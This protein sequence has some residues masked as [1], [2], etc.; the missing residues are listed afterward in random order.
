MLNLKPPFFRYLSYLIGALL[1]SFVIAKSNLSCFTHDESYTYLSFPHYS[2]MDIVSYKQSYTNNHLLNTLLMK[3]SERVFGNSELALRLPNILLFVVYMVF[4][5]LF[6]RKRK[7]LFAFSMFVLLCTNP[8]LVDLFGLARG[9]GL[10][11]GFMLMSLYFFI[12]Y[13]RQGG[14]KNILFFHFGAL[15]A[16]LSSFT[17][18]T[19]YAA[20]LLVFN[21]LIFL[22][23]KFISDTAFRFFQINKIH[24]TP[25]LIVLII[26]Y[27]PVRRVI[28]F[29]KFD[30]GGKDGFYSDTVTHLIENTLHNSSLSPVVLLVFQ[31]LLSLVVLFP[32]MTILQK[33]W[34]KDV[35][36]FEKQKALMCTSF[37]LITIAVAIIAQHHLLGSDYPIL[38][39]SIYLFP[40]FILHFGYA[41]AY[42]LD[43]GFE[44]IVQAIVFSLA[45]VSVISFSCQA[46]FYSCAEWG[47]DSETKNMLYSLEDHL[48]E[49]N[50]DATKI[51]IGIN[52][53]FEPTIL[54]YKKT[55]NLDWLSPVDRNGVSEKDDYYYIFAKDLD[56][57]NSANYEVI[58][59]FE[60]TNTLLLKNKKRDAI[61]K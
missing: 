25:L 17:L 59:A 39:F 56:Q 37:L 24:L 50:I 36:F 10:S 55:L 22:D 12:R 57:L 40:L 28:K 13:F 9:Y 21:V 32:L 52:W 19:F 23:S 4:S 1:L 20:L 18:L 42:F 38:R 61:L 30:F 49:N 5:F 14:N 11:C 26:L 43:H 16:I 31:I 27:E 8:L 51:K 44:K 34:N 60:R 15:L 54:F 46:N 47:Y 53:L 58:K 6:F 45:L 35:V 3:Y 29:N 33:V 2:F 41:L 48:K 7:G